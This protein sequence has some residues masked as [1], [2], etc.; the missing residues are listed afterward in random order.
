M[1]CSFIPLSNLLPYEPDISNVCKLNNISQY[2]RIDLWVLDCRSLSSS[3]SLNL[4]SINKYLN[5]RL[6]LIRL[7][8]DIN[9]QTRINYF[10]LIKVWP[11]SNLSLRCA[12]CGKLWQTVAK[13]FLYI[14]DTICLVRKPLL[15]VQ[16]ALD[17]YESMNLKYGQV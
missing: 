15:S 13:P 2:L 7:S 3:P 5:C 9:N 12:N 10:G 8:Q 6:S 14:I 16:G 11:V 4:K 1:R 17:S